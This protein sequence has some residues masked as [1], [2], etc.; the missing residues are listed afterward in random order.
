MFP[1]YYKRPQATADAFD[2]DG[3]YRTGDV[4]AE[5]GADRLGYVDRRNKVPKLAQGG[6]ARG[7]YVTPRNNVL[8]LAQGEF[9]TL[10]KL[11]AAFGNSRLIRQIY[12]YGNSA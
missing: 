11:E 7:G 8:K 9:V 5:V 3:Y 2:A 4:V 1:G 10:A 6:L 12:V